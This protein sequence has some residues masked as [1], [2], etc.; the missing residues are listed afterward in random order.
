MIVYKLIR[1]YR[2]KKGVVFFF[3]MINVYQEVSFYAQH[4]ILCRY[5]GKKTSCCYYLKLNQGACIGSG[6]LLVVPSYFLLGMH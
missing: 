3:R 5:S 1:Y 2:W 4:D 6:P